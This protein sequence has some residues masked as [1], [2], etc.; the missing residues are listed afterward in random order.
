MSFCQPWGFPDVQRKFIGCH[1]KDREEPAPY[2]VINMVMPEKTCNLF[3]RKLEKCNFF[4]PIDLLGASRA[5]VVNVGDLCWLKNERGGYISQGF[6]H[7][8]PWQ[9][10]YKRSTQSGHKKCGLL[11]GIVTT[12]L[13]LFQSLRIG[14]KPNKTQF[15]FSGVSPWIMRGS[16]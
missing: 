6:L 10:R 16:F 11:V 7:L 8:G 14:D 12:Q 2:R 5:W 13:V 9:R 4:Q 1:P 3:V 15:R